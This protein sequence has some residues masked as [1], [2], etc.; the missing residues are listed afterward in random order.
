M[1]RLH[2]GASADFLT[3]TPCDAARAADETTMALYGAGPGRPEIRFLE[4][5]TW[6]PGDV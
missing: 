1:L 3:D 5:K 6:M 4:P 2:G